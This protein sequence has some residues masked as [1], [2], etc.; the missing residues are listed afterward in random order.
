MR[1]FN[2]I[3]IYQVLSYYII[4][5]LKIYISFIFFVESL[6]V[7]NQVEEYCINASTNEDT[8]N[9]CTKA[10]LGNKVG[11]KR[12]RKKTTRYLT[13]SDTSTQDEGNVVIYTLLYYVILIMF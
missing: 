10:L 5:I 8:D 4:Q 1:F 13:I 3:Y 12:K 6:E 2:V 7:A 11:K 9:M